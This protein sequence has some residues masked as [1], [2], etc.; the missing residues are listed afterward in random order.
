M[1]EKDILEKTLESY[2]DVFADIANALLFEGKPVVKED[3][4]ES[5]STHSWYKTADSRLRQQERDAAKFWKRCDIRIALIGIENESVPEA[6]LP[7]RIFGYDGAE[8]RNQLFKVK[9]AK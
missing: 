1:A 8:Y 7:L 6:D 9:D 4:L 2:N 3:E 5:P